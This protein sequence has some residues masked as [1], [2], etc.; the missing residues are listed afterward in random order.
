MMQAPGP[1]VYYRRLMRAMVYGA[2]N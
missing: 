1:R 2:L